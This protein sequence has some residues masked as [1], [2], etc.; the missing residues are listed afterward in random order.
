MSS[1]PTRFFRK[2]LLIAGLTWVSVQILSAQRVVFVPS[3][4]A[5]VGVLNDVIAG[6]TL[7]SGARVD[8]ATVYKLE[9]GGYYLLNGSIENRFPLT[10]MG[11]DSAGPW[12]VLQPA[13]QSGGAAAD[14][15]RVRD[16]LTLKNLYITNQDNGGGLGLRTIR[17]SADGI[18]LTIDS[19]HVDRSGQAGIRVDNPG[20][21]IRL[22]NS[23]FSNIGVTV[24]PNNGRAID[25]RGV[26]MDSIIIENSTFFNL[27][28]TVLRDDG[29]AFDYFW[30]NHNTVL[31]VGQRG[32]DAG[33]VAW[34]RVTNNLFHNVGFLGSLNNDPTRV[35]V[36]IDSIAGSAQIIDIRNNGFWADSAALAAVF[37]VG[38]GLP[39]RFSAAAQ[40]FIDEAGT[41]DSN[42]SDDPGFVDAPASPVNVAAGWHSDPGNTPPMDDGGATSINPMPFNMAYAVASPYYSA[43]LAGQPL[44]DLNWWNLQITGIK[45]RL[46]AQSTQL[47]NYPNPFA[48]QTTI[49]YELENAAHVRLSVYNMTGQQIALLADTRQAAGKYEVTW[50]AGNHAAGMYFYR[51]EVGNALATQKMVLAK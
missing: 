12:P 36:I 38:V 34:A 5:N 3:S 45:D 39:A 2:L 17:C 9:R 1:Y 35:V 7:A 22:T 50:D 30:F 14:A 48:D 51:L 29:G 24:D 41:G 6:D 8:S 23:I 18:R 40:A 47:S 42:V 27:T 26:S 32:I 44:G 43:S 16:D 33:Q 25:D 46:L 11:A 15:F 49:R 21:T 4:N 31:N 19:C 37:P 13:V 20:I 28:S 10:I